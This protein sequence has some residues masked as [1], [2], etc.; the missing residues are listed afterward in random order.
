LLKPEDSLKGGNT[1]SLRLKR[2]AHCDG[3][4]SRV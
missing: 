4:H 1:G 3:G 2:G